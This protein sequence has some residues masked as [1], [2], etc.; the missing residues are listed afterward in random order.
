[1]AHTALVVL[2]P[3]SQ[4]QGVELTEP[5]PL[6]PIPT[7]HPGLRIGL[8][9]NSKANVVELFEGLE[10]GLRPYV[11]TECLN[12]DKGTSSL[13]APPALLQELASRCNFVITAMAD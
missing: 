7:L 3:V 1:M 8:L 6:N 5:V 4:R 12:V 10:Q 2:S 13:P 11:Q 9:G